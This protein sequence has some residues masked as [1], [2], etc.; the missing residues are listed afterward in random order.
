MAGRS[1][2]IRQQVGLDQ[3]LVGR[4][5]LGQEVADAVDQAALP[6]R[7]RP[8]LLD[9]AD[10]PGGAVGDDQQRRTQPAGDQVA[11]EPQAGVGGLGACAIQAE[12]DRLAVGGDRPGAQH[13][14]GPGA[15]VVAEVGA[16]HEHVQRVQADQRAGPP[17]GELALD[18][19]ADPADRRTRQGRL[20]PERPGQAG[21]HAV[22]STSVADVGHL[23]RS[24]VHDR[25]RASTCQSSVAAP[26][27]FAAPDP[28]AGLTG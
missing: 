3:V 10:Q 13:R 15:V 5:D 6:Q 16:V 25:K 20:G 8:D 17:G 28:L 21:L 9:R 27:V 19:F 7:G 23:A 11:Q 22:A 1:S 2:K 12:Q 4:G 26:G 24:P 18:G 14:L